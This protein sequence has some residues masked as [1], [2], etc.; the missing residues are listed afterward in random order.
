MEDGRV[1]CRRLKIIVIVLCVLISVWSIIFV[2]VV[3]DTI[4]PVASIACLFLAPI[5]TTLCYEES[6]ELFYED[7]SLYKDCCK[8]VGYILLMTFVT[9][10]FVFPLY[11]LLAHKMHPDV[12]VLTATSSF[13]GALAIVIVTNGQFTGF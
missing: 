12:V 6:E 11:F 8:G 9:L 7:R 13:F 3:F 4:L 5:G 2:S 10:S 1:G